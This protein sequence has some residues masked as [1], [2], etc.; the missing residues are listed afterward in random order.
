MVYYF[1]HGKRQGYTCEDKVKAGISA[2]FEIGIPG[3][4]CIG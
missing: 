1:G 4:S 2:G 3:V